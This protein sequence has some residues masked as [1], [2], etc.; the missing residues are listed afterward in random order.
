MT[1]RLLSTLLLWALVIGLPLLLGRPG[2]VLVILIAAFPSL[3]ETIQ[4][5][6]RAGHLPDTAPTLALFAVFT[7]LATIGIFQG[8]PP[9][10]PWAFALPLLVVAVLL[11]SPTGRF[12]ERLG[13]SLSAFVLLAMATHAALLLLGHFGEII[14]LWIIA[15]TKFGDVGALLT[16]MAIGKNKMAPQLSPKK[17][18]EG[19]GG[20]L[21][22]SVIVSVAIA[23]ANF[24]NWPADVTIAKAALAGLV[25]SALGVLGD[26][27]ESALKREANVK[28]SG[29]TFPGLGGFMDIAD[30]LILSLPIAAAITYMF[31]SW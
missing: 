21:L 14:I 23:S 29:N 13:P 8:L 22:A 16:G 1:K 11:R 27:M 10:L 9:I 15:V 6:K 12:I 17:T 31:T 25:I 7:G 2:S 3:W 4:L 30:S 19:L 28:D 24:P 5:L 18:W 20:G 26:L